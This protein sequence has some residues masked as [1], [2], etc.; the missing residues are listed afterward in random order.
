MAKSKENLPLKPGARTAI[1]E[2]EPVAA[3]DELKI[4]RKIGEIESEAWSAGFKAEI[5]SV[6]Y[7]GNRIVILYALENDPSFRP[8]M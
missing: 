3:A 2:Q 4:N 5:R 6:S 7:S 1:L 8:P